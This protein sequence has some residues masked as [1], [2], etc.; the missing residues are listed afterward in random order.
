M[1]SARF[2]RYICTS[3]KRRYRRRLA[4]K[5]ISRKTG[6]DDKENG[7]IGDRNE[8]DFQQNFRTCSHHADGE[9][10]SLTPSFPSKMKRS[11]IRDGPKI[12]AIS[13]QTPTLVALNHTAY[14]GTYLFI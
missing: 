11:T 13:R 9:A 2:D 12:G 10:G 3:D 5:K 14:Y 4:R 1:Q 6:A 8:E 7:E